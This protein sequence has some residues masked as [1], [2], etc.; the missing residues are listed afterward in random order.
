MKA[1]RLILYQSQANYRRE[2]TVDNKMTY[3]L[4][5]MSTVIGALHAACGY[6]EYHPM[7]VS[8]QGKYETKQKKIYRDNIFLNSTM[9]D[10]G[11]LVKMKN[12]NMLSQAYEIVSKSLKQGSSH[13]KEEKTIVVNREL[14]EEYKALKMSIR[15]I[16]DEI[17]KA[18]ADKADKENID[19]LKNK[20][21]DD[22]ANLDKFATL[23][24]SIKSYEI[25]YGI[26]LIIHVRANENI[27]DDIIENAY[28]I[29]SIG[30]SED[31]VDVQ[32]VCEVELLKDA[33]TIFCNINEYEINNSSYDEKLSGYVSA[34]AV[35][36]EVLECNSKTSGSRVGG[37]KYL[38][39]KNYHI[40]K[41]KRVFEKKWVIYSSEY[42]ISDESELGDE[43][44]VYYDGKYIV[45]F[46]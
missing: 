38:L 45:S 32:E 29:R 22:K 26:K 37:T 9:D 15:S 1:V 24:Q 17:K 21:K 18:N 10:R 20:K 35:K 11:I 3:P 14:L 8:I 39:N 25:L 7:D 41:G 43:T 46:V 27:I 13:E 4:P 16:D 34:K 23:N 40:E 28:N 6:K 5:P 19:T 2:E 42:G 36:D 44:N 33:D 12:P 31:F 30:R